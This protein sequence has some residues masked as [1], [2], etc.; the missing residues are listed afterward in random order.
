MLQRNTQNEGRRRVC[1]QHSRVPQQILPRRAILRGIAPS[2]SATRVAAKRPGHSVRPA[3]AKIQ[4]F[5]SAIVVRLAVRPAVFDSS[6]LVG[7][8]SRI[9]FYNH[10]VLL[11][12]FWSNPVDNKS[13]NAM[14]NGSKEMTEAAATY[15]EAILSVI[16]RKYGSIRN[17]AKILAQH[18]NSSIPAAQHWIY[19]RRVPTGES[20]LNIMAECHEMYKEINRLISERR[21]ALGIISPTE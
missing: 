11:R 19:G 15:D 2:G 10:P 20:L 4:A 16:D 1:D 13:D 9:G 12:P 5:P 6:W 14:P 21:A 8:S 3:S 7:I 17:G 18:A